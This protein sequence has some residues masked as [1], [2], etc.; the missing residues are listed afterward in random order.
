MSRVNMNNKSTLV[1]KEYK[2]RMAAAEVIVKN[3]HIEPTWINLDKTMLKCILIAIVNEYNSVFNKDSHLRKPI[4][5]YTI[6]QLINIIKEIWD[7]LKKDTEK[8]CAICFETITSEVPTIT[9]LCNHKFCTKCFIDAS[10]HSR[11]GCLE[12]CPLCR[13]NVKI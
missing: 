7:K 11:T 8:D 1:C 12:K 13:R 4:R 9:L 10:C 5:K 2:D 6:H 3:R